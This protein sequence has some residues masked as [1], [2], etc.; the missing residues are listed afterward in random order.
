MSLAHSRI[1]SSGHL[2]PLVGASPN[3]ICIR[4]IASHI[5]K[6]C[7][8][9]GATTTFYSVAQHSMLV[10]DLLVAYGPTIQLYGLM[11][12]AHE[13]YIGDIPQPVKNLMAD[14]WGL[15]APFQPFEDLTRSIDDAI[16]R[17][18]GLPF[19]IPA[20]IRDLIRSAD[21]RALS[22]EKRDL[23]A[24]PGS[25]MSWGELPQP[26][27]GTIKPMPWMRAEQRFLDRYDELCALCRL[28][29]LSEFAE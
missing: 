16:H 1:M 6:I 5:A 22:T 15:G 28:P 26:A 20:Q 11:H 13:A 18:V 27:R 24:E 4:S 8:F 19:P 21:L 29:G 10:S 12:D 17:R 25:S 3:H 9:A 7:R 2:V 23:I 14:T